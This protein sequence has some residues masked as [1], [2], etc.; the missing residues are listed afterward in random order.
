MLES[1]RLGLGGASGG[2]ALGL[3]GTG[4][5]GKDVVTRPTKASQKTLPGQRALSEPSHWNWPSRLP[6]AKICRCSSGLHLSVAA[7]DSNVQTKR[8]L[9]IYL[10]VS[11]ACSAGFW[12]WESSCSFT[13]DIALPWVHNMFVGH[14]VRN[15]M[16]R[17][18]V[19]TMPLSAC[20]SLWM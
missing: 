1:S 19:T 3:G 16:H 12:P 2:L 8:H 15:S 5:G 11:F 9:I 4:V 6:L 14:A 18:A 17:T 20:E 10:L 13:L 7:T